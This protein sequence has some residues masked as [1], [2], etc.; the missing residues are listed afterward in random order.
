MGYHFLVIRLVKIY[1][2]DNIKYWLVYRE[3]GTLKYSS[4]KR[5]IFFF[6]CLSESRGVWDLSSL[7][8]E[9]NPCP[10]HQKVS[11]LTTGQSGKS[12]KALFLLANSQ[13]YKLC[14]M[15]HFS[16]FRIPYDNPHSCLSQLERISLG[17]N[18]NGVKTTV[19]CQFFACVSGLTIGG[20]S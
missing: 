12:P 2:Y 7:T 3:M 9:S 10:L 18:K 1:K 6:F 14:S 8:R 15:R 19:T 17:C 16:H 5:H 13:G 4:H 20:T 11:V